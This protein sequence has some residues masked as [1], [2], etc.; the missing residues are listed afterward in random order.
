VIKLDENQFGRIMRRL[1][2]RAAETSTRA[3]CLDEESLAVYLSGGLEEGQR[4]EVESHLVACPFCLDD[5][6]GAQRAAQAGDNGTAPNRVLAK[7]SALIRGNR[8]A[9]HFLELVVQ[10]ARDSLNLISTSGELVLSTA[11]LAIRSKGKSPVGA[12]LQ[13]AK[14]LDKF[15]VIVEVERTEGE[16]CRVTVNVTP[17][18]GTLADGLRLSLLSGD[19]EQASYLT[20][21]GTVIFDRVPPDEYQVMVYESGNYLGVIRLA[22]KEDRDE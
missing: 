1:S 16:L 15:R 14:D 11:P 7:A 19:R 21:Q 6:V 2:H 8:S 18:A 5:L 12:T 22:I 3:G 17:M 4:C 13:V 10:L 20:R 9:P